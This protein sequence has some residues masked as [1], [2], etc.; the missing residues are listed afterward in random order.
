MEFNEQQLE[1]INSNAGKIVCIAAAGSGKSTVLLN[2]LRR[3]ISEGADPESILVLTFTNAAAREM[4][5][6]FTKFGL[7][8]PVFGTFHAFCYSLIVK[9]EAVRKALGYTG[10]P[11]IATDEDIRRIKT[12]AKVRCGIKLS[13]KKLDGDGSDLKYKEKFEYNVF[14]KQ[15]R[16][17]LISESLIT[18]DMMCYD[19]CSLFTGRAPCIA[20][21][22]RQFRYVYSDE[23]QDTDP[24]QMEFIK[25]FTTAQLF[26]CGD[27]QQMLYRFRGCTNDIIK[28]LASD[29]E[30][31]TIKLPM[32]Y[33][34]TRQI[35][36]YSNQIFKQ[37]WQGSPYYL[38]GLSNT[39]GG[40]VHLECKF[41]AADEYA[42]PILRRLSDE[43]TARSV[44]ILCRT[45]DEVR[46][47]TDMLDR[48][49]I[50]H[51]GRS[52]N[53][54][55]TGI[56]KSVLDSEYCISWISSLLPNEE[57]ARYIRLS[58]TDPEMQLEPKFL[59]VFGDRYKWI[60]GR[61]MYC[62]NTLREK[63]LHEAVKDIAKNLKIRVN[64]EQ[65]TKLEKFADAI[66]YLVSCAEHTSDEGIY[67]GTIHSVK[68]L[69]YDIVHVIGVNG[70]CFPVFRDEDNMACFYVA[71]TRA[72]S[73]L[74][75]WC[76]TSNDKYPCPE[77]MFV[78]LW[79]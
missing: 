8:S 68:G 54:E 21:Y 13:D 76:E 50:S 10:I 23:F 67:V 2:R 38:R 58:A 30:W 39:E 16:K 35:V 37:A 49:G 19:V 6:R 47:I 7:E 52:D 42:A 31:T 15:V 3:I 70:R 55:L 22:H 41:P 11:E 32:N 28:G 57:Y 64:E 51:K 45:N 78:G 71:C 27:P 17:S 29:P 56:L 62:R 60:V 20:R 24:R 63:E 1:V 61:I 34:S 65:A 53:S 74:T 14:H 59:S 73:D 12:Q 40:D 77:G 33:R 46:H 18:F 79:D 4:T 75:I 69:E 72:K 9:D 43:C 26:V 66:D 44:A 25:S 5:E 36:D 48:L